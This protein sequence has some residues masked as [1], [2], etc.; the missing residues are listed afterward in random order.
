MK[1]YICSHLVIFKQYYHIS[2]TLL[3]TKGRFLNVMLTIVIEID[4]IFR[5]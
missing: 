3:F 2:L 5:K 1:T 4:L